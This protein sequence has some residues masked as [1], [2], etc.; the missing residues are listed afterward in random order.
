MKQNGNISAGEFSLQ[1]KLQVPDQ[2]HPSFILDTKDEIFSL[3]YYLKAQF[4]PVD[5]E[6]WVDKELD[7]SLYEKNQRVYVQP[8]PNSAFN[9]VLPDFDINLANRKTFVARKS[10]K[11]VL[12]CKISVPKRN[13]YP[14]AEINAEISVENLTKSL[15]S[16]TISA[17]H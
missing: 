1:F 8:V 6:G 12:K 5:D 11:P 16:G 9:L 2:L 17:R 3:H 7:L 13:Y 15:Q 4:V 10:N 14:G